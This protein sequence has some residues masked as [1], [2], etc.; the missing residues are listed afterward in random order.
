[1]NRFTRVQLPLTGRAI[2]ALGFDPLDC[3]SSAWLRGYCRSG[4]TPVRQFTV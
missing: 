4:V 1:M 2:G 3:G